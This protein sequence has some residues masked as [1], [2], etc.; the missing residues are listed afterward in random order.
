ME[1]RLK[2]KFDKLFNKKAKNMH[3]KYFECDENL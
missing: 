1:F 3:L 2:E